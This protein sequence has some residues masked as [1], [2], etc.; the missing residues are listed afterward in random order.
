MA[1]LALSLLGSFRVSLDAAAVTTF[2]S[3]K[4]RALLA[5]LAAEADRPHRRE[6]LVGMLWPDS[7]EQVARR[8][9]SQALFNLRHTIGD[10]EAIPPYLHISRE[11]IQFHRAS[12]HTLDLAT[13]TAVRATQDKRIWAVEILSLALSHP[14]TRK[15]YKDEA[16]RLLAELEVELP[17]EIWV[18]A[19]V[20]GQ[21]NIVEIVVAAIREY[22]E[23][24]QRDPLLSAGRSSS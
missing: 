20:R 4:V 6:A 12:Q 3:D 13:F 10:A 24:E 17:Q 2:E 23:Q 15:V 9:L 14:A 5:Y 11:A 8:N 22:A 19:R 16:A 7:S 1:R 21:A 18:T